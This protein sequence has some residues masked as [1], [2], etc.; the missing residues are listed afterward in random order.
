MNRQQL[1]IRNAEMWNNFHIILVCTFLARSHI[2]LRL[3]GFGDSI[4][5][6]WT[7][8]VEA[9]NTTPQRLVAVVM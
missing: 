7:S 5:P 9:K 2:W 6:F 1:G 4:T 8:K 3:T